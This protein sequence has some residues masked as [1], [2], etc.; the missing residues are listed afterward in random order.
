MKGL[1]AFSLNSFR[2]SLKFLPI[3]WFAKGLICKRVK[4]F[5]LSL[6]KLSSR[7]PAVILVDATRIKVYEEGE[8]KMKIHGKGRPRKWMKLH[9]TI[10][11]KTH[12]IVSEFTTP[13]G[14][15]D[16]KAFI[17]LCT[18]TPLS[19]KTVKRDG[20]YNGKGV[21]SAIRK[22]KTLA[23]IPPPKTTICKGED[24]NRDQVVMD[25]RTFGGILQPGQ[26]GGNI[27]NI[28]EERSLRLPFLDI[29]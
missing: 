1:L 15:R 4:Q 19:I 22:R 27:Q 16:S 21:R 24:L 13:S 7:I 5:L 20:V 14:V 17:P 25:I 9:I 26:Y 29:N 12:E 2:C 8:W 23:L 3:L 10:N 11:E 18:K 6:P 28:A